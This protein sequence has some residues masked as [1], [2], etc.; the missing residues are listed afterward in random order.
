METVTSLPSRNVYQRF[1]EV[2]K[3]VTKV[4]KAE[5]IKMF[6]GDK[7]YKAVS[8]D[9][10]A[11]LLH[12]P[13]A[14]AGIVMLPSVVK[15]TVSSFE[16]PDK[17]GKLKLWYRTDLELLVKY[18]NADDPED[19]FTSNGG[20][21]AMDT[22][23]KSYSKAYSLALKTILLK[24]HLLESLDQEE[25]RPFDEANGEDPKKPNSNTKQLAKTAAN[26]PKPAPK[27]QNF[28][29]ATGEE[30]D[31]LIDL[32][33]SR[34]VTNQDLED[35]AF[36][37]YNIHHKSNIPQFVAKEI[38]NVLRNPEATAS[39]LRARGVEIIEAQ[40]KSVEPKP[41]N[42]VDPK[43]FIMPFGETTT[44]KRLDQIPELVLKGILAYCGEQLK[45]TPPAKNFAE[46]IEVNAKIKA[47][48][49]TVGV[50]V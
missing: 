8:H 27:H 41:A 48:L 49:K 29:P 18:I 44:G 17:Y 23:D 47:F 46:I 2:Q 50:E 16:F 36:C 30:L 9:D 21:Y 42:N 10:V 39:H 7:G 20:A 15:S 32:A 4:L 38:F 28:I 45:K 11:A 1:I 6:E 19:Y 37:V 24:V 33:T 35:F 14:E 43:D 22:S 5:T 13:L 26:Q 25:Q 40:R 31:D 12:L 34:G 3:K